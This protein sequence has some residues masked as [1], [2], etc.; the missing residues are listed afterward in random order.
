MTL[1]EIISKNHFLKVQ[2]RLIF[3][4]IEKLAKLIIIYSAFT[5]RKSIDKHENKIEHK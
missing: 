3:L 5:F 4:D 2:N 1:K